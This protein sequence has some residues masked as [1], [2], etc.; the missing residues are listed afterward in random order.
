MQCADNR[1]YGVGRQVFENIAFAADLLVETI[2]DGSS[3][4]LIDDTKNV[5]ARDGASTL[6]SFTLTP[7]VVEVCGDGDNC[8]VAR[9]AE[10]RLCGLLRFQEDHGRDF[11]R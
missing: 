6:G 9:C 10:V 2:G 11:F 7:Q 8:I 5:H 4:G 3:G 1:G